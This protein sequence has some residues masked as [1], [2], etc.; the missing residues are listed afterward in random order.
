MN[1]NNI[2]NNNAKFLKLKTANCFSPNCIKK[3]AHKIDYY[4]E[5]RLINSGMN[6][7]KNF[8]PNKTKL[9][10]NLKIHTKPNTSATKINFQHQQNQE[11]FR[12]TAKYVSDACKKNEKVIDKNKKETQSYKKTNSKIHIIK[13]VIPS[14]T[15]NIE[16]NDNNLLYTS[17]ANLNTKVNLHSTKSSNN[18]NIVTNKY[19]INNNDYVYKNS[20]TRKLEANNYEI[21]SNTTQNNIKKLNAMSNKTSNNNLL[22]SSNSEIFSSNIQNKTQTNNF[23]NY[24][25]IGINT[26]N[27]NSNNQIGYMLTSENNNYNHALSPHLSREKSKKYY[28]NI[29]K[30]QIKNR[31]NSGNTSNEIYLI[32][33]STEYLPMSPNNSRIMYKSFNNGI[34]RNISNNVVNKVYPTILLKNKSMVTKDNTTATNQSDNDSKRKKDSILTEQTLNNKNENEKSIED[35]HFMFVNTIQNGRQLELKLEKNANNNNL[36][37]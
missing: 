7:S 32:N 20:S 13:S 12:K 3:Q 6:T 34:L 15:S 30:I 21:L 10:T 27:N 16:N 31:N 14:F 25:N 2:Y 28:S 9:N 23:F 5:A 24:G 36:N 18:M 35:I 1:S 22:K 26:N 29:N 37:I 33:N 11:F 19:N 8:Y 4:S 17:T